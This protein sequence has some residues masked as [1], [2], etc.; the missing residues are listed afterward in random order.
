MKIIAVEGKTNTGKSSIIKELVIDLIEN[1]KFNVL[2]MNYAWAGQNPIDV[3]KKRWYTKRKHN[4][5][6]IRILLEKDGKILCVVSAG[7]SLN[8]ITDAY[9]RTIRHLPQQTVDLFVCACHPNSPAKKKLDTWSDSSVVQVVKK[10]DIH[11]NVHDKL[12]ETVLHTLSCNKE[13]QK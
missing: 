8:Q 10:I 5:S 2:W 4:V 7:D 3:I 1:H 12:K 6:D 13:A 11:H 9:H